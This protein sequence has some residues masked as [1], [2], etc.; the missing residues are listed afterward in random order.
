MRKRLVVRPMNNWSESRLLW[1]LERAFLEWIA[2]GR[3]VVFATGGGNAPPATKNPAIH[4]IFS[5]TVS[6]ADVADDA[7][8]RTLEPGRARLVIVGRQ[9]EVEGTRIVLR[10]LPR[11][12]QEFPSVTLD[13]VG[14]GAALEKLARLASE[15]RMADR[16]TFHGAMTHERVLA[17]LRQADVFCL[18]AVEN[19]STRQTVIEALACGLPVVTRPMP[20]LLDRRCVLLL[21]HESP[22]ALAEAVASLLRAPDN[23]RTLSAEARRT[24]RA[25]SLERWREIVRERLEQAWGPLQSAPAVPADAHV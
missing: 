13:V 4:W 7:A 18:P 1:R 20:F 5:P 3:T 19:E 21:T 14:H 17:L 10:S 9:L 23:Y 11:L 24:A 15:L 25:Y 22:E 6:E 12:V 16:V 2:D 8:P